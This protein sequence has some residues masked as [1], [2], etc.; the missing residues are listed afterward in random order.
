[1]LTNSPDDFYDA[2]LGT[3]LNA[4]KQF[5]FWWTDSF[6]MSRWSCLEVMVDAT[7]TGAQRQRPN[8]LE[9]RIKSI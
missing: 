1:M 2:N 9:L 3:L 6:N 7:E 4:Q 8:Q 5:F